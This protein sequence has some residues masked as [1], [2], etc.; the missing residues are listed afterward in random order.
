MIVPM[1]RVYVVAKKSDQG[2]LLKEL[3]NMGLLHVEAVNPSKAVPDEAA[4]QD[5]S[6][7]DRAIGFLAT[8]TPHK[9]FKEVDQ[10]PMETAREVIR[11]TAALR[12]GQSRLKELYREARQLRL[13]GDV[14][15]EDLNALGNAGMEVRFF[16]VP[17]EQMNEWG[18]E[19]VETVASLSDDRRV[20]A[21]VNRKGEMNIPKR[22]EPIPIP[23]RD[24]PSILAEAAQIDGQI[25]EDS[26]KLSLLATQAERLKKEREIRAA[27]M[28][29]EITRRSGLLTEALFAIQ[30]W[31]PSETTKKAA[32]TLKGRQ[33]PAAIR[34]REAKEG[35][36]PPTLIHYPAWTRPIKALFDLL[37]TLPGYRE[38]DLSPVF[39]IALP[40]FAAM[41]IGDAG[42]GF[43]LVLAG[44]LFYGKIAQI[45]G[46]EK[47][48][49]L[50]VFGL[51]T[52]VWG[53]LTANY[54]GISPETLARAGGFVTAS[55]D[56]A[57]RVDYQGLWSGTGFYARSAQFM[58][59]VAPLWRADP[60]VYRFLIIKVSLVMGCLHLM[61][62]HFQRFLGLFPD[63]RAYAEAGWMAAL[64]DML[65][66]IWYL[67]FIG[68]NQL[69]SWIWW[70]L[71]G[72]LLFPI[73]FGK[74]EEPF[75]RRIFFGAA[76]ML[77]PVINT[78]SDT[79]SYLR[80]FA[81]GMASYYIAVAFNVLGARLAE[82]ATW[83]TA[84]PVL[85]F[86]HSLN[87]GL[88]GIAIFAHGVRLNMLE[89]SNNA[90][91]QWA[92]YAYRPYAL[93]KDLSPTGQTSN[94]VGE[95]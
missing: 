4:L 63:R 94:F 12:D 54:F 28:A 30:G 95:N 93:P 13:W 23:P 35:E 56:G 26:Q 33:I 76:A 92:G 49:L 91:V 36:S 7:L 19:C 32:S 3:G 75:V 90:G 69:P 15:I 52:L 24:R 66:L 18:A 55:H 46:R 16:A 17:G 81:V 53:V 9:D 50:T 83:F 65:A 74:P 34:A 70:V 40:M 73:W 25:R 67:L 80:L 8:I 68:I 5:L 78:F 31:M 6:D 39:M 42:Y 62:A 37:G 82:S 10:E 48:Q 79:M 43:L 60:E 45:A 21:V 57:S 64:A 86:G 59:M 72:A 22:A 88:A 85:V 27:N 44:V 38:M 29:Q 1:S 84:V 87:I 14:R 77:L 61:V 41:L 58:R 51:A 47:A 11:T 2:R 20:V 71:L 89:F